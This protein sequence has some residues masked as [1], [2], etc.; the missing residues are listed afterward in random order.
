MARKLIL[1]KQALCDEA[2]SESLLREDE[3]GRKISLVAKS[4]ARRM[5]SA[6]LLRTTAL[7]CFPIFFMLSLRATCDTY[8]PICKDYFVGSICTC[9]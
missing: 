9:S 1:E 8:I 6:Y 2:D 4:N 3:D 7:D 5:T